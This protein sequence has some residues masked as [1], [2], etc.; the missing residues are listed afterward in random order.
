MKPSLL[1]VVAGVALLAA[2]TASADPILDIIYQNVTSLEGCV[3][4]SV[5][6]EAGVGIETGI[7]P[8]VIVSLPGL[9][10]P[11]P[12]CLVLPAP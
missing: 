2:G 8:E 1:L 3:A 10:P 6:G 9:T 5:Q 4:A 11:S 7:P 12:D